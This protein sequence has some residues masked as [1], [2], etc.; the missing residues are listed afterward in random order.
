MMEKYASPLTFCGLEIL[1]P[2][3]PEI[4]VEILDPAGPEIYVDISANG[5]EH[6]ID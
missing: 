1:D 6:S 4:Y 5:G 2:A 3:G